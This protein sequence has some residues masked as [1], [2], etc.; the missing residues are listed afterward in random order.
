MLVK[1]ICSFVLFLAPVLALPQDKQTNQTSQTPVQQQSATSTQTQKSEEGFVPL[2]NGKNLDGWWGNVKG[3]F[4][5]NGVLVCDPK[6]GGNIF[7]KK[8]Y[9]DFIL[10]L[11][12]KVPPGGNNGIAI[13]APKHGHPSYDGME[14]Q[15]LDDYAPQYAHLKP[16]QYNGS[17]YGVVAA[18]RGHLKPAGQ[19]NEMEIMAKGPHIR[20]TLNG[21]VIVDADLSKI[22]PK[23]IHGRQVKGVK[24]TKGYIGFLGHGARVEFRNIRIKEL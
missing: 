10:R 11:E 3:Y 18:K 22:G 14:I 15:I 21:A 13:R 2:F 8:Q 24:R 23:S 4:V 7:T 1:S 12:Y 9:K 20:V 5:E 6:R 16:E 17:I 19:W